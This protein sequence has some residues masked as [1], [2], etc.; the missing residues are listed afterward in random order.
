MSLPA[1]APVPLTDANVNF[2]Q[3]FGFD[4]DAAC[5]G[6][7]AVPTAP[8]GKVCLYEA[9]KTGTINGGEGRGGFSLGSGA[10]YGFEVEI[11]AATSTGFSNAQVAGSWAYTA[12]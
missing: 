11:T 12:P 1:E 5:D 2:N 4:G 10:R 8:P 3:N 7:T 9:V 6:T